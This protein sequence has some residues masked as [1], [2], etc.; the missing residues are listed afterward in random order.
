MLHR[1][2]FHIKE[3]VSWSSHGDLSISNLLGMYLVVFVEGLRG[4][5]HFDTFQQLLKIFRDSWD[6]MAQLSI[7]SSMNYIKWRSVE[8]YRL[9]EESCTIKSCNLWI[10]KSSSVL[11]MLLSYSYV[12]SLKWKPLSTG[13]SKKKVFQKGSS[14]GMGCEMFKNRHLKKVKLTLAFLISWMAYM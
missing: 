6:I 5:W 4:F 11:L 10:I 8:A 3:I 2:G 1:S 7:N 9:E 14:G 12:F 13:L